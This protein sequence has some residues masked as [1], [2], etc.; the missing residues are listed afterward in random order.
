MSK[1]QTAVEEVDHLQLSSNEERRAAVRY[2][3]T[4]TASYQPAD[5][6][7]DSRQARI[8]DISVLGVGLLLSRQL[9][10]GTLLEI[11][12]R[13]ANGCPVR[14]VL[15][16]VVHVE[17]EEH[18]AWLVG[19]AFTTEL[20][21]AE[22]RLFQAERVRPAT[23]DCRRWVRFPC[24]V[25]TVCYT[26]QTAPGE[27]RPARVVNVS[28]GGIGLLLPCDF[29][30]GTLLHFQMPADMSQPGRAML[31]RVVRTLPHAKG[32]WFLGCEFADRLGDEDLRRLLR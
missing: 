3:V 32:V 8:R 29:A 13:R 20:T 1:F 11:E 25:E 2:R 19:C 22:L 5:N 21:D 31:V 17:A 18:G 14:T 12:L 9:E 23:P 28:A 6:P 10:M 7:S 4:L 30:E 26:C 16:R 15:A 24:N 27:S